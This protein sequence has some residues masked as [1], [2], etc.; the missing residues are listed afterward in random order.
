MTVGPLR[1]LWPALEA[2]RRRQLLMAAGLLVLSGALEMLSLGLVLPLLFHWMRWRHG[3]PWNAGVVALFCAA[4]LAAALVRLLSLWLNSRLAGAVGSD[5]AERAWREIL[6]MSYPQLMELDH[7]QVVAM[8]APQLRQ[9][10]Q[11]VLQQAL[12]AIS[13]AALIIGLGALLLALAWQAAL[14]ALVVTC[15]SYAGMS[16]LSRAVLLR[17]G[18]RAAAEQRLLIR[19]LGEALAASRE[20][21]L[22]GNSLALARSYGAIDRRMRRR[23]ADNVTL[24]GL[25][26]F[27]L[28]PLGIV[29]LT[30]TGF[31]LLSRGEPVERVLP[32]LG[33]L[34]FAA[35]RLLPLGQQLWG[36]W[37]TLR[38]NVVLLEPLLPLLERRTPLPPAPAMPPLPWQRVALQAVRFAYDGEPSPVLNRFSLELRRGEWLGLRGRSGSGKT[39][40]LDLLMG[41]LTPQAGALVVDGTALQPDSEALRRWQAGLAY[42]GSGVCL[43]PA[44]LEDNI[45]QERGLDQP[46]LDTLLEWLDLVPLRQRLPGEGGLQLSSGQRQRVGLARALYGRPGLLILDEAT[47]SLD[48]PTE[49]HLLRHIRRHQRELAVILV[50]H[51]DA[52][53][54]ICDRCLEQTSHLD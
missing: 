19:E 1:R 14:P 16:W 4:V 15:C 52:S 34:A 48:L 25:P 33:V 45:R 10:I 22:R 24:T 53:L 13:A 51:R 8:L 27:V 54:A 30:I 32:L 49:Q 42:L 5:I 46:W 11:L 43:A 17:N 37:A 47:S 31:L 3:G 39:T 44:C 21:L 35:Q 9:L 29:T 36:G 40:V 2:Q 18:R 12:H 20:R 50:S 28:E 23:E 26:R 7:S 41:L 38:A 6:L